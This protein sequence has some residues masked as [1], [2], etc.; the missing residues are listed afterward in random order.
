MKRLDVSGTQRIGVRAQFVNTDYTKLYETSRLIED[1][2]LSS[3]LQRF[4]RD[5]ET[6]EALQ[7]PTISFHI[8]L[9]HEFNM[10]VNVAAHQF[11]KVRIDKDG[12]AQ[13]VEV[14]KTQPSLDMD[15]YTTTS[16]EAS[17]INGVM[18]GAVGFLNDY[19]QKIWALGE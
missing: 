4:I 10:G 3:G 13:I 12:N 11:G 16:K 2:F 6:T 5:H 1:T 7:N 18:R 9:N 15:V 17:Q 8:P 19:S 14:E